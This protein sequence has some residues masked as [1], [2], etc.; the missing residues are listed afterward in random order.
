M[1]LAHGSLLKAFAMVVFGLLLGLVGTDTQT[2][3][4]RFTLG[5]TELSDGISVAALAMGLFGIGD[6]IHNLEAGSNREL[7]VK[8]VTG[9]MPTR[10]D[11]KQMTAPIFRGTFVGSALG[12]LPGGGALLASFSAYA[13]E[14]KIA[15]DPSRFG[16][17]AIEGVA[18]PEAANNAG[19]QTSFV[20][21]LT[22][23][24]PSNPVMALMIGAMIVQGIEPGP[25]VVTDQ[26]VLFWGIIAS[27]WI[28]NL[29]LVVL[30]L[31]LV[32]MWAKL[33]TVPYHY[34]YPGVLVFSAIGVVQCEQHTLRRFHHGRLRYS[35]IP[36]HQTGMRDAAPDSRFHSR[37][38]DGAAYETRAGA[39]EGRRH[40]VF[41]R[42]NQRRTARRSVSRLIDG[43][44]AGHAANPRGGVEGRRQVVSG[45]S[46][47]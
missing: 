42:T 28:G 25:G 20:P 32:G 22:L 23:G 11:M 6:I 27:M 13:V 21:M 30:N 15:R 39:L 16:K 18:G 35:R 36:V 8:R 41:H 24:I 47:R 7:L 37:P 40:G 14:K 10:E 43:A 26:P 12:I 46:F 19:A 2:G 33:V 45:V 9:L 29:M 44:V 34:L 5:I 3:V 1:V 38:D 17:G 4:F 31:P